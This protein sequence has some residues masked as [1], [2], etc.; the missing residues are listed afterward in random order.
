MDASCAAHTDTCVAHTDTCAAHTHNAH[1]DT[2]T[3]DLV[4]TLVNRGFFS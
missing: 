3:L 2:D 1:T 4:V